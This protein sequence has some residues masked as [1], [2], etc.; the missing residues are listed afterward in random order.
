MSVTRQGHMA[1]VEITPQDFAITFPVWEC[2]SV[3]ERF[4]NTVLILCMHKD[5][6]FYTGGVLC[7]THPVHWQITSCLT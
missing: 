4:D 5:S 7:E 1:V 3:I 6:A 2:S